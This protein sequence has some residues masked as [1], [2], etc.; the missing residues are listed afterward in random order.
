MP[1]SQ[2]DKVNMTQMNSINFPHH[3]NI[4]LDAVNAMFNVFQDQ[5]HTKG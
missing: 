3:T 1:V 5:K 2:Y 4:Y